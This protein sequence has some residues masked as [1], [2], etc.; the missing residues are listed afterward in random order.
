MT[1]GGRSGGRV[2]LSM[3]CMVIRRVSH[4]SRMGEDQKVATTQRSLYRESGTPLPYWVEA[5][6]QQA[7]RE[8]H[9]TCHVPNVA[10]VSAPSQLTW[11]HPQIEPVYAQPRTE[12]RASARRAYACQSASG[13]EGIGRLRRLGW[14]LNRAGF[15]CRA[16][17]GP[18]ILAPKTLASV[19]G[20][21][22]HLGAVGARG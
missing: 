15:S 4:V 21:S 9:R 1:V 12:R 16:C 8:P 22:S 7:V 13:R 10:H 19:V 20:H 18:L 17:S 2:S 5:I 6:S 11:D 14:Q 3:P